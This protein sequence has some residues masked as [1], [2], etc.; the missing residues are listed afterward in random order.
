MKLS[1]IIPCYNELSTIETIIDT[2]NAVNISMDKEIIIVD[3][4]SK[5]GTREPFL[6]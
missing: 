5:D 3:D 2:V 6:V 4:Y 1:I